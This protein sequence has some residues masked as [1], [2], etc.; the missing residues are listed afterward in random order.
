VVLAMVGWGR[1]HPRPQ[2]DDV[3]SGQDK[4]TPPAQNAPERE[5]ERWLRD[6]AEAGDT[7][8]MERLRR[9]LLERGDVEE[10]DHWFRRSSAAANFE[11]PFRLRIEPFAFVVLLVAAVVILYFAA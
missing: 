5:S 9:L 1:R 4:G 11:L 8:A 2:G 7:S 10:D 6:A 3:E